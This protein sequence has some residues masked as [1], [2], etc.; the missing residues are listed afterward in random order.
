MY[1]S[2]AEIT[3]HMRRAEELLTGSVHIADPRPL[4]KSGTFLHPFARFIIPLESRKKITFGS[5]G[6]EVEAVLEPGDA[7]FGRPG[8]WID[9]H[10]ELHHRMI[11]VVFYEKFIRY[12]Y[13]EQLDDSPRNGPDVY[14]HTLRPP[15]AAILGA[16]AAMSHMAPGAR[17]AGC[18]F[19]ALLT[20]CVDFLAEEDDRLFT[21]DD[22]IW[23]RLDEWL[24]LRFYHDIARDDIAA[25]LRIHPA[26]LSRLMRARTGMSVREYLNSIRLDYA[27][28]LLRDELPVEEIS[29]RCG[30]SYPAYFIRLFRARYGSTP[31]A[32]RNC[33]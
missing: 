28:K 10:F 16:V 32:F 20:L 15:S 33:R 18:A 29:R 23:S 3:G 27:A 7:V 30:F 9:E 26:K 6:R 19:R 22:R 8:A 1:S 5:Q 31:G 12:L 13:I 4:P 25:A 17:A 2:C 24:Q 14:V 21:E 11:S